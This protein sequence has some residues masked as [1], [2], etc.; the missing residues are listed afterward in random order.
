MPKMNQE[1][2]AT[3][4]IY[5]AIQ[6]HIFPAADEDI[7]GHV[8]KHPELTKLVAVNSCL[9]DREEFGE[10]HRPGE[11]LEPMYQSIEDPQVKKVADLLVNEDYEEAGKRI[12][13]LFH[14]VDREHMDWMEEEVLTLMLIHSV[15]YLN[16][17]KR[18]TV[19]SS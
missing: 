8:K 5:E 9:Y 4:C 18:K 1:E 16:A 15:R 11:R 12:R 10:K 17:L 13:M 2:F 7:W 6:R 3:W 14:N 19:T